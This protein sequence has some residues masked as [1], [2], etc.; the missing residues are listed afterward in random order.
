MSEIPKHDMQAVHS[1][2]S[3]QVITSNFSLILFHQFLTGIELGDV[4]LCSPAIFG[5]KGQYYCREQN[6]QHT[7]SPMYS[8]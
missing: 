4:D 1:P 7:T 5:K 3:S 6:E 2:L 8:I